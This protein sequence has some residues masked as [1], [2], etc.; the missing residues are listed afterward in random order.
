MLKGKYKAKPLPSERLDRMAGNDFVKILES[1]HDSCLV[2]ET[3]TDE[4]W[5][6][7]SGVAGNTAEVVPR[8]SEHA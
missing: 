1:D 3:D 6:T 4:D 7:D 8:F 2:G 5:Y